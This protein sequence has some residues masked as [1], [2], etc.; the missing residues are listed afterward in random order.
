M[1]DD[2]KQIALNYLRGWFLIDFL[3]IFPFDQIIQGEAS[4]SEDINGIV[5][6]A[7]LGRMYKLIKLTRLIRIIKLMK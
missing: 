2:R 7:R 6:I 3:A 5:R 4:A 1:V